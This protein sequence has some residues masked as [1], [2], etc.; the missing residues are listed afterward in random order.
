[1]LELFR[2]SLVHLYHLLGADH[3][4]FEHLPHRLGGQSGILVG[5]LDANLLAP[6]H[7]QLVAQ[8]VAARKK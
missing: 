2:R 8:F 6:D 5:E 4:G 3:L 1:M 7:Q